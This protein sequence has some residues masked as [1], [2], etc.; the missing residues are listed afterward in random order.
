MFDKV[1][2]VYVCKFA[3]PAYLV[4]FTDRIQ[5]LRGE[6]FL[7]ERTSPNVQR[8]DCFRMFQKKTNIKL[9]YGQYYGEEKTLLEASDCQMERIQILLKAFR[10]S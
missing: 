5:G 9:D 6:A 3:R 4:I 1:R 7:P 10:T 2:N 8:A